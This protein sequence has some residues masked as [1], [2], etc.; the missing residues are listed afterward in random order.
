MGLMDYYYKY[1]AWRHK[2][3]HRDLVRRNI[4]LLPTPPTRKSTIRTVAQLYVIG[5]DIKNIAV[6]MQYTRERVRQM[7]FKVSRYDKLIGSK[8][9]HVS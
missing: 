8:N 6:G 2:A 7:L 5:M 4:P 3:P 1:Y 9:E